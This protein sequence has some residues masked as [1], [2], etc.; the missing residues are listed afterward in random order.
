MAEELTY[1][2]EAAAGY[3]RAFAHITT[4]FVPFLLRGAH[5]SARQIEKPLPALESYFKTVPELFRPLRG[6][7]GISAYFTS[8]FGIQSQA[9]EVHIWISLDDVCACALLREQ[10][11]MRCSASGGGVSACLRRA[12]FSSSSARS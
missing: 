8:I 4:H 1:K 5:E 2:N 7:T 9:S 10:W 6:V 3:D 11:I 12:D